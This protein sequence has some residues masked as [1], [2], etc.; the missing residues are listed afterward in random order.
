VSGLAGSAGGRGHYAPYLLIIGL[1]WFL[2]IY[3]PNT[4]VRWQSAFIGALFG[5][6]AWVGVGAIFTRIAVYATQTAAIYAGFAIVLLVLYLST[7]LGFR[8]SQRALSPLLGL[9]REVRQLDLKAPDPAAFAPDRIPASADAEVH[10]LA[11]ALARFA[12]RMNDFV[13]RERHFTR[14]ASHELRSP[15]TVIR[16]SSELLHQDRSLDP[17]SQRAV[18][19]IQRAARDME[20][21][22]SAFLLLA[23][24]RLALEGVERWIGRVDPVIDA[25]ADRI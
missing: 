25:H 7:W 21:L 13:D 20:E 5:G 2:Y 10:E 19:R 9:A 8:A 16:A 12:Q 15:L 17:P 24:D 14:D 3:M 22:T 4:R 18:A 11:A 1:F 23:R 6:A